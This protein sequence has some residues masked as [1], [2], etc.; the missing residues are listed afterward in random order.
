MMRIVILLIIMLI[1]TAHGQLAAHA[2]TTNPL[3]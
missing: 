2:P 1:G 3:P